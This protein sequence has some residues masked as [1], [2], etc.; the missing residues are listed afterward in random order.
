MRSSI[1]GG[2]TAPILP[3]SCVS[4]KRLT[5]AVYFK[6]Q[7]CHDWTIADLRRTVA[8]DCVSVV[9]SR[10]V[11]V[12]LGCWQSHEGS[13]SSVCWP[14]PWYLCFWHVSTSVHRPLQDTL[15]VTSAFKSKVSPTITTSNDAAKT[16]SAIAYGALQWVN[17]ECLCML[18]VCACACSFACVRASVRVRGCECVP[19]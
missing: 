11:H 1:P 9:V 12:S 7:R 3:V 18:C 17:C 14:S 5:W 4:R 13:M 8:C 19:L 15:S 16:S 6:R 2:D 10:C